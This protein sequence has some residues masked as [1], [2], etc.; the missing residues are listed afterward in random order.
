[1][2]SQD[3]Y[4]NINQENKIEVSTPQGLYNLKDLMIQ[5][6]LMDKNGKKLKDIS[7]DPMVK[8]IIKSNN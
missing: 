8:N 6:G 3:F 7:S 5:R 4:S 2:N 1:M